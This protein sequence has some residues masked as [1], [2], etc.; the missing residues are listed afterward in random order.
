MITKETRRESYDKLDPST[1]QAV[2]LDAFRR[3]G[4]MT[5]RECAKALGYTDLN[6]VKPRITELCHKGWLEAV[7]KKLDPTTLRNVAV[8]HIRAGPDSS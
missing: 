4:D 8:F 2:I 1:R 3:H 6:A 7:G 5:A